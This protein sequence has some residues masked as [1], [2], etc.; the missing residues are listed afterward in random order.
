MAYVKYTPFR[1]DLQHLLD[2]LLAEGDPIVRLAYFEDALRDMQEAI[3]PM[4]YKAAYDAR[5]RATDAEIAH[6]TGLS[7]SRVRYLSSQHVQRTGA[8]KPSRQRRQPGLAEAMQELRDRGQGG[9]P[10][11]RT[12]ASMPPR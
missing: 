4:L 9:T 1:A 12:A 8:V 6:G 7:E 3:R 10:R 11:R 2:G 5:C